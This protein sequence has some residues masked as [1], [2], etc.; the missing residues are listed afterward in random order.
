MYLSLSKKFDVVP[1][2]LDF[3]LEVEIADGCNVSV[4]KVH[5]DCVLDWLSRFGDMIEC[6]HQ[7]TRFRT[8]SGGE[9]TIHGEGAPGGPDIIF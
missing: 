1:G 8:S 3:L 6:E 2:M 7:L 9:L 4:L 5:Q